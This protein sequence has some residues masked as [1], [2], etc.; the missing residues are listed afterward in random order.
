MIL[1]KGADFEMTPEQMQ[2]VVKNRGYKLSR[3]PDMFFG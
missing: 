2:Y 3:T 1:M